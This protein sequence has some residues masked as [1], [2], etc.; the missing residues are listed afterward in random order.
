MQYIIREQSS[1][2][3]REMS[4]ED[5]SGQQVFKAHGPVVRVRDELRLL[6]PQGVEQAYIKDPVLGDSS[7]F[8]IYRGGAHYADV[9]AVAVGNLLEGYDIVVRARGDE[10]FHARGDMFERDFTIGHHGQQAARV[11]RQHGSAIQV[12]TEA[13]QDDLLLLAGVLAIVA[14]TDLRARAAS[15]HNT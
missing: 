8:E 14:M 4:I 2:L 11:R 6:N 15:R 5:H 12:D 9:K 7:T 10:P 1:L 3:S 13:G